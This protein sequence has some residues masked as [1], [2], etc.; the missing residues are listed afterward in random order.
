MSLYC[1]RGG[2]SLW[3]PGGGG[4]GGVLEGCRV[5]VLR[6]SCPTMHLSPWTN[7]KYSLSTPHTLRLSLLI[8]NATVFVYFKSVNKLISTCT[9]CFFLAVWRH[10]LII[11]CKVFYSQAKWQPCC[12]DYLL[13]III[14]FWILYIYLY[15][16]LKINNYSHIIVCIYIVFINV[17]THL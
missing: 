3:P 17:Y 12:F 1:L 11:H 16:Q 15:T 14:L 13:N 9:C 7:G 6:G 5:I 4:G 10:H 2:S 8:C